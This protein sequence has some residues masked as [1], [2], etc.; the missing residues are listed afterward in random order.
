M[1][2][3]FNPTKNKL[4]QAR[5]SRVRADVKGTAQTPRLSV[6][7]SLKKISAQLIDDDKGQTLCAADGSQIKEKKAEGYGGKAAQSFL[8]GKLLAEKAQKKNIVKIVFD[9]GG[10]KYHG[11]VKA[12][13]EGARAGGLQF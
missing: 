12:L 10:Y 2:R 8:T 5:H 13:A 7:R 4:R 6:F 1:K 11:R 9:R 3:L